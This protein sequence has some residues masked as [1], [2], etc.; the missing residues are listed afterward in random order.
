MARIYTSAYQLIGSTPL[1]ELQ[2]IEK[3]E[4]LQLW[5]LDRYH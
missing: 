2:A 3:Q 1:L 4:Q 5:I